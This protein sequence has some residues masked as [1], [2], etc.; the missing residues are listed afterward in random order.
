MAAAWKRSW[1]DIHSKANPVF[2]VEH[3]VQGVPAAR[4]DVPYVCRAATQ[5]GQGDRSW[6]RVRVSIPAGGGKS[7]ITSQ[8]Q[9]A[10]QRTGHTAD[11]NS[12]QQQSN[13][14]TTQGKKMSSDSTARAQTHRSCSDATTLGVAG[15]VG[16]A[17]ATIA[18]N[19]QVTLVNRAGTLIHSGGSEV[20]ACSAVVGGEINAIVVGALGAGADNTVDGAEPGCNTAHACIGADADA[21][22]GLAKAAGLAQAVVVSLVVA[23]GGAGLGHT[24]VI[25]ETYG[26]Q[27][28]TKCTG[29]SATGQGWKRVQGAPQTRDMATSGRCTHVPRRHTGQ[30]H[31]TSKLKQ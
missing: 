26:L 28:N 15:S 20:R 1:L 14:L 27:C 2:C 10:S 23:V 4:P 13:T 18:S 21:N 7:T 11:R 16:A 12:H 5:I 29:D 22:S 25:S 6:L 30:L 3:W 31:A 9:V 17:R 8:E 24:A 19:A